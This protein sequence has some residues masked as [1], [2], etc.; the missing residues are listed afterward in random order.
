MSPSFIR[1]SRGIIGVVLVMY[2]SIELPTEFDKNAEVVSNVML[3]VKLKDELQVH[4]KTDVKM[5]KIS[6]LTEKE[7]LCVKKDY[8]LD[9]KFYPTKSDIDEGIARSIEKIKIC[10]FICI[11]S[12]LRRGNNLKWQELEVHNRIH[13]FVKTLDIN[14]LILDVNEEPTDRK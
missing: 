11:N 7:R 14:E 6:D 1:T 8:N 5:L 2:K 12:T 4:Y 13:K 9:E 10:Q 3:V